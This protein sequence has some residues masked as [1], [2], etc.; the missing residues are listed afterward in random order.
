MPRPEIVTSVAKRETDLA[1][2]KSDR[3]LAN[4]TIPHINF[5]RRMDIII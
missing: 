1:A 4:K 3:L 5:I 2:L